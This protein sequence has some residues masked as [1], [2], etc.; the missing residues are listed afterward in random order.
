MA[1]KYLNLQPGYLKIQA[2]CEIKNML[3]G[4]RNIALPCKRSH[5][6]AED[7][8]NVFMLSNFLQWQ[9]FQTKGH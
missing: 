1:A 8:Q 6:Y 3:S 2:G 9:C 5:A 4:P 7:H